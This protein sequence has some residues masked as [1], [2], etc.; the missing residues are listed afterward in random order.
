LLNLKPVV[1]LDDTGKGKIEAKAFSLKTNT[2]KIINIVKRSNENNGI[3]RYAILHANDHARAEKYR[4]KFV[5]LL[6]KEPE[7]I[8]NISTI[9]GL[10]AGVGS[11][12][13]AYMNEKEVQDE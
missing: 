8:M 2:K 5:E 6:K 12:A 9:V 7:Y 3:T 13:I 10:S 11:V 1:S 4:K